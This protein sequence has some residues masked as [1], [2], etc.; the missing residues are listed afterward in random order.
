MIRSSC[1]FF[2]NGLRN[3]V[4]ICKPLTAKPA[5]ATI[6]VRACGSRLLKM[7][8]V[9]ISFLS[10]PIRMR[11]TS[12]IGILTEPM[13]KLATKSTT[14]AASNMM[15]LETFTLLQQFVVFG[16]VVRFNEF[17]VENGYKVL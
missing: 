11:Q 14:M 10:S 13:S 7:M 1:F 9:Q 8:F 4:C 15:N 12:A 2:N 3:T 16:F 5:P 17:W 6:A